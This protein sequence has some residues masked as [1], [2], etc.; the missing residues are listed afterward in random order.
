[1]FSVLKVRLSF[2][3]I[4]SGSMICRGSMIK[5][6]MENMGES[7]EKKDCLLRNT[8]IY[9]HN[10]FSPFSCFCSVLKLVLQNSFLCLF[11]C[12]LFY[13]QNLTILLWDRCTNVSVCNM[14]TLPLVPSATIIFRTGSLEA[15]CFIIPRLTSSHFCGVHKYI[16][17]WWK[18]PT[19]P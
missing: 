14:K 12:W 16:S 2:T 15:I 18:W 13:K 19:N 10:S 1:M 6:N 11:L 9:P 3:T 17:Y 4:K 8:D 5:S 7:W